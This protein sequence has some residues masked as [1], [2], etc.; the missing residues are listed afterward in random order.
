MQ[1]IVTQQQG[2]VSRSRHLSHCQQTGTKQPVQSKTYKKTMEAN[3][4]A[5]VQ[6]AMEGYD[7]SSGPAKAC[8]VLAQAAAATPAALP[9]L[10]SAAVVDHPVRRPSRELFAGRGGGRQRRRPR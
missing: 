8:R 2:L 9:G 10:G 7:I 1:P 3:G 5:D 4:R 6:E